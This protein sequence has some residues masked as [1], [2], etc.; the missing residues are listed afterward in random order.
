MQNE[1]ACISMTPGLHAEIKTLC[2]ANGIKME[3]AYSTGMQNWVRG[4]KGIG[5]YRPIYQPDHDL[6]ERI[7]LAGDEKAVVALRAVMDAFAPTGE[8]SE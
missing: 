4:M 3:F 8:A 6:L 7:L 5:P 1:K 2:K